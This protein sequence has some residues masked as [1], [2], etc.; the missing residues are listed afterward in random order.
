MTILIFAKTEFRADMCYVWYKKRM[1]TLSAD[2]KYDNKSPKECVKVLDM[3][4]ARFSQ[5]QQT[6]NSKQQTA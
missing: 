3:R 4:T 5:L 1:R 6:A 2:Y